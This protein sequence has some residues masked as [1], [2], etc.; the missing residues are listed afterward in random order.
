MD[1]TFEQATL[2]AVLFYQT[3]ITPDALKTFI[4]LR[5]PILSESDVEIIV[6]EALAEN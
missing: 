4:K 3:D 6:N 5:Y 1:D 2:D